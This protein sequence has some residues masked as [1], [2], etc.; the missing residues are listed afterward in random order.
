MS[1]RREELLKSH[2]YWE[3]KIKLDLY[4]IGIKYT[5]KHNLSHNEFGL[6]FGLSQ[7]E[8]MDFFNAVYVPRINKMSEISL[9]CGYVPELKFI[10]IDRAIQEDDLNSKINALTRQELSN[11]S[12]NQKIERLDKYVDLLRDKYAGLGEMSLLL[13]EI[14]SSI[15]IF[16]DESE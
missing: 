4:D 1:K 12:I 5:N 8:A 11:L 2:I 15:K 9:G 10:D 3:E 7:K 14:K 6:I 13:R 16:I